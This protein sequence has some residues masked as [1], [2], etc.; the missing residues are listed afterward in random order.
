MRADIL[1]A[2]GRFT[3]K[4]TLIELVLVS[5]FAAA[6]LAQTRPNFTGEWKLDVLRS[7]LDPKSDVKSAT[8]KI[9]HAEPRLRIDMNVQ[10]GHGQQAFLLDLQTDGTE[11]RQMIEERPCKAIARWGTRTGERL[12]I[13]TTCP[14]GAATV[15]TTREMKLGGKGKVLTTILVVKDERGQRKSYEFLTKEEGKKP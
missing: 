2:I 8:M 9:E 13:E 14:S 6:A 1:A 5:G 4:S 11:S 7:R 15:V 3:V 12:R 10:T